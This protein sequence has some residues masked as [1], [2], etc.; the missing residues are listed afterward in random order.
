MSGK[1]PEKPGTLLCQRRMFW[2]FAIFLIA[3]VVIAIRLAMIQI[4]E[5]DMYS[6]KADI[7]QIR[8]TTV[9]NA[10]GTIYDRNMNILAINENGEVSLG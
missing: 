4:V 10:R 3:F 5:A 7:Q 1:R 2:V 6:E 9:S 8:D